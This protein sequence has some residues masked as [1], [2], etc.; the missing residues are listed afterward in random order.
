MR[1]LFQHIKKGI[2]PGSVILMMFLQET[3][4]QESTTLQAGIES[5]FLETSTYR[6]Q[7]KIDLALE[8]LNKAQ[9]L[10]E[11]NE[12]EKALIDCYHKFAL[13]YAE[14]D[15]METTIFYWDRAAILLDDIEYPYG[16][17]VHRYIEAIRLFESNNNF[18]ALSMLNDA[19]QLSNDRNLINNIL[20]L[21]AK[22]FLDIEKYDSATK[23][24]NSLL[25]NNDAF[26]K[27]H[28]KAEAHLGLAH[29]NFELEEYQQSVENGLMALE[30]SNK[31]M[32]SKEIFE[33]NELLGKAYEELEQYDLSLLYNRNLLKIKD[34]IF[35]VEKL[36]TETKTADKIQIDFMNDEIR[37][38]DEKIEELNE[39]V[40]FFIGG[41]LVQK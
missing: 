5:Y 41:F 26:E 32:F 37:R 8:A 30:I 18:Q 21:E 27:E 16:D 6:N 20:L 11:K 12:D 38:Q 23:N 35:T 33:A 25:I 2:I 3:Y 40:N 39:N 17:A 10:A 36:K 31:N 28:L 19:K 24:F 13:L 34:S 22:I 1:S 14:M 15:K 29:L 9:A 4:S 7:N